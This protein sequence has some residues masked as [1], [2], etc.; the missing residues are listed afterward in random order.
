LENSIAFTLSEK[1]LALWSTGGPI[2]KEEQKNYSTGRAIY[3]G[4]KK[5]MSLSGVLSIV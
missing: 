3:G 4:V 2:P 5:S 1:S